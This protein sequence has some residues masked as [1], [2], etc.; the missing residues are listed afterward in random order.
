M[1]RNLSLMRSIL[2][3]VESDGPVT[4]N[5]YSND[6]VPYNIRL[7]YDAGFIDDCGCLT[8]KGEIFVEFY[9]SDKVW[10]MSMDRI[11]QCGF[12]SVPSDILELVYINEFKK[13]LDIHD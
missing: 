5:K 3:N 4:I 8:D 10:N 6:S 7:C 12:E 2:M 11:K 13:L 1:K 9:A